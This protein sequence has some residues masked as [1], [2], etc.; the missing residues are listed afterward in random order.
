MLADCDRISTSHT[1]ETLYIVP[2]HSELPGLGGTQLRFEG[3][4]AYEDALGEVVEVKG[5]SSAVGRISDPR[6]QTGG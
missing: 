1:C 6:S 3:E 4:V 5:G 2:P